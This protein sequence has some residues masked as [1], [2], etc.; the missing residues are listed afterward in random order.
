MTYFGDHDETVQLQLGMALQY[1]VN[2]DS[3]LTS[4]YQP[5]CV[6]THCVVPT[7]E[8]HDLIL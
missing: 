4:D 8:H 3:A 1:G 6:V 2:T 5:Y 7:E